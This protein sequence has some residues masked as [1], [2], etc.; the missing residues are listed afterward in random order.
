LP[1]KIFAQFFAVLRRARFWKTK[2]AGKVFFGRNQKFFPAAVSGYILPTYN[3]LQ[4]NQWS[5]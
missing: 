3:K 4:Q 2:T 5:G 1:R